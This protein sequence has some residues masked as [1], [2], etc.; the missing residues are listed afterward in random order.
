MEAK[1]SYT[2]T[3]Q[4]FKTFGEMIFDGGVEW[5]LLDF[6]NPLSLTDDSTDW[7]CDVLGVWPYQ[8]GAGRRFRDQ[9]RF[10]SGRG[11]RR[12]LVRSIVGYDV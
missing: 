7:L 5:F 6:K 2:I 11:G 4:G 12:I 9:P 3:A 8:G 10:T 1:M